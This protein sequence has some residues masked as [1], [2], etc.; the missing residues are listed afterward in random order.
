MSY[1]KHSKRPARMARDTQSF[2]TKH[3]VKEWPLRINRR[4]L[5]LSPSRFLFRGDSEKEFMRRSRIGRVRDGRRVLSWSKA[6]ASQLP[7]NHHRFVCGAHLFVAAL[8]ARRDRSPPRSRPP[9]GPRAECEEKNYFS[10]RPSE[11]GCSH[12]STYLPPYH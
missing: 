5:F 7:D 8:T 12:L 11:P 10:Y 2:S 3:A 1:Y 9:S 6:L 4:I